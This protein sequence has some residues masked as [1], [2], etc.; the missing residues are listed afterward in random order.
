[1]GTPDDF[2]KVVT[3]GGADAVAMAHVLHYRKSSLAEIR[4]AARDADIHVR[5][6]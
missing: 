4:A 2:V 1:M 5:S 6:I 3:E